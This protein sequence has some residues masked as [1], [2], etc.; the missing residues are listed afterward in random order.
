MR[1]IIFVALVALALGVFAATEN[2]SIG[3][4]TEP[5]KQEKTLEGTLQ[6]REA[7]KNYVVAAGYKCDNVDFSLRSADGKG[8]Q[9]RCGSYRYKFRDYGGNW[10]LEN[11]E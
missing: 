8:L 10:R 11:V 9:I 2:T 6:Q 5:I 4:Y 1:V 3:R 7:A